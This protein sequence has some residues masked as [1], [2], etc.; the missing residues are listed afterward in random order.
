LPPGTEPPLGGNCGASTFS[1]TVRAIESSPDPRFG[2]VSAPV[3]AGGHVY[4][5]RTGTTR[6]N[7]AFDRE[8][9]ALDPVEDRAVQL[10]ANDVDD[11]LLDA[12]DGAQLLSRANADGR[13]RQILYRDSQR[14]V[15][16]ARE[17]AMGIFEARARGA[18]L[19]ATN[20]AAWL[21][22]NTVFYFDGTAVREVSA[23]T[24][25]SG[26]PT[27]YGGAVV[28]RGWDGNSNVL[29]VHFRGETRRFAEGPID[30]EV[31]VVSLAR[32]YWLSQGRVLS[33]GLD[34]SETRI[35][36]E[37][38]CY[39][40]AV[41]AIGTA[42][43]A[44]SCGA[45]GA[46]WGDAFPRAVRR[47]VYFDGERTRD[48]PTLGGYVYTPRLDG[49]R[50][51][52]FEFEREDAL[53]AVPSRGRLVFWSGDDR[54]QPQAVADIGAPCMCCDAYWAPLELSFERDLLAWNYARA[55]ELDVRAFGSAY[56]VVR[57][58]RLC[59]P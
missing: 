19:V 31:P 41:G 30:A 50:L 22:Q 10:T 23:A 27:L 6:S 3:A 4:F 14:E 16:L 36:D 21:E 2:D 5:S 59:A 54:V 8:V 7:S 29:W 58:E 57:E 34:T 25:G 39:E 45:R 1:F 32:V 33:R 18:R 52:W 46:A 11:L 20:R 56:A 17:S 13:T 40:L 9:F 38:P 53:C 43:V 47:I 42:G 49:A 26:W 51:A 24:R 12:R 44:M 37:G 28:W 55:D 48:V 35:V 15:V